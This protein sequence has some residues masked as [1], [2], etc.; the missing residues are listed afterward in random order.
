MGYLPRNKN[1]NNI[2]N[3]IMITA[4]RIQNLR[5]ILDSN[6]IEFK[7][8]MILLGKNSSGKSTFLRSFPL[9]TQSVDKRLRGPISWFDAAYVDFGDFKTAKN[10]FTTD[11]D[12]ISFTY[13]FRNVD[14]APRLFLYR[15]GVYNIS[16]EEFIDGQFGFT[17]KE[18]AKGTYISDIN[19][20]TTNASYELHVNNRNDNIKFVINGKE[21]EIPEYLYFDFNTSFGILP[22]IISKKTSTD[23]SPTSNY[24]N[25]ITDRIFTILKKHC[26]K[27]LQNTQRLESILISESLNKNIFLKKLKQGGGIKSF[28]KNVKSWEVDT[29]EFT[30]IYNYFL[31]LKINS[32]ID[33]LNNAIAIFYHRCDYIAPMRAEADRYYRIQGLQVQSIDASGHNL[34]EFIASLKPKEK[35][36]LDSFV[37]SIL[38]IT[39]DVT[40]ESGM[41]SLKIRASTG[42]FNITDV[43]YGY[44]QIVPIIIKL[45]H[46]SYYAM[47]KNYMGKVRYRELGKNMLLIEQPELHLHP[48]MQAK[49]ADTFIKTSLDL[50]HE[51]IDASL[52]IETHSPTIVNRIGKRIRE[53][54]IEPDDV[55]VLLFEKDETQK[56]STIK[57]IS[58]SKN[59]Q[60]KNWPF[61]FFD[62][63]D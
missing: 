53:G 51:N 3:F 22:S 27:R 60:L 44:S 31:L 4:L 61:G 32:I 30:N 49:V 15:W 52:I 63:T 19:I 62:P 13:K 8:I 38:N 48:A 43:G 16:K 36:S 40:S 54:Q 29:Q 28:Q 41:K 23:E 20:K 6:F 39:V 24:K 37:K 46:T 50:K 47:A 12:G 26:D 35:E 45:W 57:Q 11:E 34:L 55:N 18:D 14:I 56:I 5:S 10:K 1:P 58:F 59:G 9:F 25:I 21:I 42:D 7:P 17:L 33:T 2:K